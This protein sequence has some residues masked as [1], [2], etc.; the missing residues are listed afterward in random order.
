VSNAKQPPLIVVNRVL[1]IDSSSK[2]IGLST[3]S[4]LIEYSSIS[5]EYSI[6]DKF[7]ADIVH[8]DPAG[9]QLRDSKGR[10][11]YAASNRTDCEASSKEYYEM[12]AVGGKVACRVVSLDYTR[13]CYQVTLKV[14]ILCAKLTI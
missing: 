11:A 1:F 12:Y 8:V 3:K 14:N 4:H 5:S 2:Q 7:E 6:G 9:V 10:S 13:N